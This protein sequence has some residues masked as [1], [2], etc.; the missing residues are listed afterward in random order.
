MDASKTAGLE[1]CE[2]M[3]HE[4]THVADVHTGAEGG[5]CVGDRLIVRLVEGGV[6]RAEAWNAWHAVIFAAS[7]RQVRESLSPA[8]P[9]YAAARGLYA[10]FRVPDM[11][12]L[13]DRYAS[14]VLDE[15]AFAAA[16]ARRL[17]VAEDERR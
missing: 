6:A 5:G 17:A 15:D 16:V 7:A 13:W 14:G 11:P 3:L 4:A 12:A 10:Y 8:H 9:D 1:L 2:T